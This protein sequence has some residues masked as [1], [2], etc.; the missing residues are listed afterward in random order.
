MNRFS[1]YTNVGGL[2]LTWAV[3]VMAELPISSPHVTLHLSVP[4]LCRLLNVPIHHCANVPYNWQHQQPAH[5]NRLAVLACVRCQ[6]RP[7][8]SWPSFRPTHS[9]YNHCMYF[10]REVDVLHFWWCVT[11]LPFILCRPTT[12]TNS[13]PVSDSS[14][15]QS[16]LMYFVCMCAIHCT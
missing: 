4:C 13:V 9:I 14:V 10:S 11:L 3:S 8:S 1:W 6:G 16:L 12:G 2:N 7:L 5:S 15:R